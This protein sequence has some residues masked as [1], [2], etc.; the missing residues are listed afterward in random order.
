MPDFTRSQLSR[1]AKARNPRS[2]IGVKR[3]AEV[4]QARS[5]FVND[6]RARRESKYEH[7]KEGDNASA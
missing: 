2:H 7:L 4:D 6:L 1:A 3:S 5:Q